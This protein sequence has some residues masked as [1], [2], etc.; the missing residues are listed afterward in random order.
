MSHQRQHTFDEH[1]KC[2]RCR[3]EY[4]NRPPQCDG[5]KGTQ[6][7]RNLGALARRNVYEERRRQA[8]QGMI[9]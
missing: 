4:A 1:M 2:I 7:N 6:G 9:R 5:P 3:C 8:L